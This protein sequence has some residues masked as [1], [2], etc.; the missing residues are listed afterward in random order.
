[1]LFRSPEGRLHSFCH[2]VPGK[3]HLMGVMLSTGGSLRWVRDALYTPETSYD[4]IAAE[5]DSV[6]PGAEGLS[7]AP[8]LTG[9]RTPHADPH[10]RG[11]FVGLGLHHR[12]PHMARA[13]M[14]G[15]AFGLNDSL[16]LMRGLGITAEELRITGGGAKGAVWRKIMAAAFGAGLRRMAIDEGPAFGAAILGAVGAGAFPDVAT[17]CAAMVKTGEGEAPDAELTL[18][19]RKLYESFQKLYP[20]LRPLYHQ[21]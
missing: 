3:W 8:Y 7:F 10:A 9:E 6:P 19:Y 2:A 14:E 12:R 15:I 13:A 4:A 5:A 17:A 20:A 11:A 16:E 21:Q 1:M 18:A